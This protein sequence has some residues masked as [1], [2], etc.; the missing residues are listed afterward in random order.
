MRGQEKPAP[1]A[2]SD[3][4]GRALAAAGRILLIGINKDTGPAME[5]MKTKKLINTAR[6]LVAGDKGVLAMEE[7]NPVPTKPLTQRPAWKA[8]AAHRNEIKGQH[9]RELFA[10]DPERGERLTAEAAGLYLDY[11][12]NLI[13]DRD[14]QTAGATG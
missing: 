13:T 1:D 5:L 4:V 7:S 6:V 3:A 14:P 10:D 9:L 11:S 2:F 8:L 12:K